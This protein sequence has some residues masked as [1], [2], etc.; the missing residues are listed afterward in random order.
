MSFENLNLNSN[1]TKALSQCGYSIPT[2]IQLSS[3]PAILTG[4][5]LVAS[6]QTGTGKTAAFLLPTLHRI[7]LTKPRSKPR[8]LI[9]TPT[10]EL[11]AQITQGVGKYGKFSNCNIVS[12][13]GG[14]PY[15]QQLRLLS[16][17]VDIIV[18]TPGRLLDH[19]KSRK[20]DL[21]ALE[22][23]IL[24]EADRMLDMGFIDDVKEITKATPNTRQTLFFSATINDKLSQFI[25]AFLKDPIKID[26]SEKNLSPTL[27]NQ[28]IYLADNVQHKMRLL[29]H[30]LENERVYKGIIFSATKI[31]ADNLANQLSK[32]GFEA[33][34]LHGDL[35]QNVRNKTIEKLR[36]GKIQFLIATDVASRGID[37][38]DITHVI[39][40]D[41]PRFSEDYV[42]RIGRTGRAGKAGEA[43]SFILPLERH[44]LKKIER[45]VGHKLEFATIQGLE[46]TSA[47]SNSDK[48]SNKKPNRKKKFGNSGSF[49]KKNKEFYFAKRTA[50][51][52]GKKKAA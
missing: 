47:L 3:I 16:R 46:P 28:K 36:R 1:I 13:V 26:L 22:V 37:I 5:D 21:S 44:H 30:F 39:N 11:A 7:S 23:L 32:Q 6:A 15:R 25:K 40:Y 49:A 2:P 42:H 33:A 34:A 31:N 12:L 45:F 29:K 9:L 41:I 52:K 17:P 48:N 20:V 18:A 43:I 50:G 14:M 4:K 27:I 24:D 35:K 10:R 51:K 8:V 19:M 38:Q